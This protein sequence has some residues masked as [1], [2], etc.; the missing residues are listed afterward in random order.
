M[1]IILPGGNIGIS[2][3]QPFPLESPGDGFQFAR[4]K[5]YPS[6]F[7]EPEGEVDW[8]AVKWFVPDV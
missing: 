7:S 3:G 4:A 8:A 6:W 1:S 2:T 5:Y